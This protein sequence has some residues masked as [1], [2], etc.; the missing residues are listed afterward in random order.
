MYIYIYISLSY[1][2]LGSYRTWSEQTKV[3]WLTNELHSKVCMYVCWELKCAPAVEA[4]YYR[5]GNNH[6]TWERLEEID[7]PVV[8]VAGERSDSHHGPYLSQLQARFK[9]A[10]L[11]IVPDA[12]HL[13]PMEKPGTIADLV[14]TT[15]R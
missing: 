14:A 1:L 2:G 6:D 15:I 7:A 9:R 5:E 8:L 10:H 13:V 11:E 4:D 3:Q 12:G